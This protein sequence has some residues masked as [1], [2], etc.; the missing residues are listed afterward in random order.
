MKRVSMK[1]TSIHLR[2][3]LWNWRG[4]IQDQK[5]QQRMFRKAAAWHRARCLHLRVDQWM[6]TVLQSAPWVQAKAFAGM[7]RAHEGGGGGGGDSALAER[8]VAVQ[9]GLDAKRLLTRIY[10]AWCFIVFVAVCRATGVSQLAKLR[11]RQVCADGVGSWHAFVL[12][13][14]ACKVKVYKIEWKVEVGLLRRSCALWR[15]AQR[16]QGRCQEEEEETEEEAA[17]E[18]EKISSPSS[19]PLVTA[20]SQNMTLE[21]WDLRER[22][23]SGSREC[24]TRVGGDSQH[25]GERLLL[26]AA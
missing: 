5:R 13:A 9:R 10:R 17:E 1:G 11:G 6:R 23:V 16:P 18:G 24:K 19:P 26:S 25:A 12:S 2:Q 3:L 4:R 21:E 14:R 8:V 7:E 15:Q 22:I 20:V